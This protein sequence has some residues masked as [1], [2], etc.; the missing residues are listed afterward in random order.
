MA[1]TLTLTTFALVA[2]GAQSTFDVQLSNGNDIAIELDG[3]SVTN[4][5]LLELITSGQVNNLNPGVAIILDWVDGIILPELVEIDETALDATLEFLESLSNEDLE[6]ILSS[7]NFET[8]DAVM[9]AERLHVM[10]DQ[11]VRDSIVFTE[12]ELYDL[13]NTFFAPTTTDDDYVDVLEDGD[14]DETPTFEDVRDSIESFLVNERLEIPG[15]SESVLAGLRADAGLVIYSDYF[16]THYT[17]FLNAEFTGETEVATSTSSTVVASINNQYFMLE[18]FF[19]EAITRHAFSAQSPLLDHINLQVLDRVYNVSQRTINDNITQ[20]KI[21]LLDWFYPQ[22]EWMGLHTEEAI[23]N[24]FKLS[25]LQELAFNDHVI[26]DDS[27]VEYLHE[28]FAQD[29]DAFHILVDDYDFASELITRLQ[30]AGNDEIRD[31]FNE[32]AIEYSTDGSAAGGGSLGRLSLPSQMVRE[33]E[34][35][36]FALGEGA[37]SQT[38]VETQFGFHIIYVENFQEVP[39]LNVIRDQELERLRTTPRYLENVMFNLRSEQN[40]IFHNDALQNLYNTLAAANRRS[41]ED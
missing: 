22:M 33:F 3:F 28:N 13:Y 41:I 38:P 12:E 36:T 24:W 4:Q 7:N 19:N 9:D 37:F 39:S 23:F 30:A 27:R 31:L 17:N 16:A 32:L 15:F 8:I 26:L 25:H 20:A 14:E 29:R 40:I 18:D 1:F 34:D 2:C 5:E 6:T 21:D 11:A 10:R 35:A